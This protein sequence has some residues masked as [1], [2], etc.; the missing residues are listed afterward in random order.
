MLISELKLFAFYSGSAGEN[1]ARL[2]VPL[3]SE[4]GLDTSYEK[5]SK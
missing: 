1:K 4:G 3:C 5:K 2:P